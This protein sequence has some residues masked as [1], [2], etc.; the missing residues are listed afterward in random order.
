M[1]KNTILWFDS[2]PIEIN[3]KQTLENECYP[4]GYLY[5]KSQ[6]KKLHDKHSYQCFGFMTLSKTLK[7]VTMLSVLMW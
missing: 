6:H 1:K 7:T 4:K 3:S 5:G 2:L